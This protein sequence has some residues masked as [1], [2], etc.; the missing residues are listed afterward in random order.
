MSIVSLIEFLFGICLL[1]NA[2]VFIPQAVKVY[3]TRN[4]G[5]LSLTTFLGFN[6]VQVFTVLHGYI[7]RDYILVCGNLF[8]LLFCGVVTFLIVK[9]GK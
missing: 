6:V 1:C 8:S 9:Y 5:G 3:R 7:N 2:L 4:A